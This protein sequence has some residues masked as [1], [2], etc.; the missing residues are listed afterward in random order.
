M[1][2]FGKQIRSGLS[3]FLS[4][5]SSHS[6][7]RLCMFLVVISC[8]VGIIAIGLATGKCMFQNKP[9]Q[10]ADA[11]MILTSISAILGVVMYGKVQ[12]DKVNSKNIKSSSNE[13]DDNKTEE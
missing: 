2:I 13:N 9:V 6:S 8:C 7:M 1:I 12:Q 11:A 4:S 3:K 5:S 10:G